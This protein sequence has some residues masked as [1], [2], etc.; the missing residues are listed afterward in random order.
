MKVL[1]DSS[2]IIALTRTGSL[3][4]LRKTSGEIYITEEV[5]SEVTSGNFPEIEE[6][7]RGI[8]RWIKVLKAKTSLYNKFE[9]LGDGERSILSYARG[10]NDVLLIL[11]EAEARA[12]AE[13]E[14]IPYTGTIGLIIF[15]YESGNI[16]KEGA[17]NIV[18]RL[19]K[20]DFRMT[21]EL[22]DWALEKLR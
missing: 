4:L 3:H 2:A 22:Y 11:D 20:S 7:K 9:G 8:G 6:I 18:R 1:P 19:A 21:V 16:S 15:A 14:R 12:I 10:R 13:A 5:R 17:V